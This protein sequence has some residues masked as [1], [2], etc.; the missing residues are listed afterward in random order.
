MSPQGWIFALLLAL[1]VLAWI[2]MPLLSR[3]AKPVDEDD[4]LLDKQRERLLV[5]YERILRNIRDLDE[6]HALEKIAEDEYTRERAEWAE[7]GVQVL[8]ALDS[9]PQRETIAATPADDTAVD[10]AIDD[11][12]ES[13]VRRYRQGRK[14]Q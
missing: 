8:Q 2:V 13:A 6:D 10:Q 1:F 3:N 7:R 11:M 5:Y 9:L 12:I 4:P 14:T